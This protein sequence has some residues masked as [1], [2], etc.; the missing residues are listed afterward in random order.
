M[1]LKIVR[2]GGREDA[3]YVGGYNIAP[4]VLLILAQSFDEAWETMVDEF[5]EQG[6]LRECDGS[7]EGCVEGDQPCEG[8]DFG[9]SGGPYVTQ[10]LVL[11][12]ERPGRT[13]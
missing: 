2:S 10:D 1:A 12:V 9:S 6:S 5:A 7:D 8:C 13:D 3:V 11:R 4:D